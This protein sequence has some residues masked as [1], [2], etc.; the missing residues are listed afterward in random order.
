MAS[1]WQRVLV[2]SLTIDHSLFTVVSL[3]ARRAISSTATTAASIAAP[4][5]AATA[6]TAK[7][8]ATSTATTATA[9]IFPRPRFVDGQVATVK[10]CA[11]ELL[12]C[13]L[14]FFIRSHLHKAKAPRA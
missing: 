1:E 13:F 2:F 7:A 3:P 6:A 9:T 14:T 8:A 4:A 12:N 11:V 10:V 5:T